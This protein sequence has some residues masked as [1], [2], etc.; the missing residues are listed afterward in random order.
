MQLKGLR[1]LLLRK[2]AGDDGFT[3]LLSMANDDLL[4]ARVIESLAKMSDV[5]DKTNHALFSAAGHITADREGNSLDAALVRDALGHHLSRYKAALQAAQVKRRPG[6]ET[7]ASSVDHRKIADKHLN[8]FHRIMHL[9]VHKL[10]PN[11]GINAGLNASPEAGVHGVN[12]LNITSGDSR[13]VTS[14][15]PWER[16]YLG[17]LKKKGGG[18]QT[19]TSGWE[20]LPNSG[21]MYPNHRY[22]EMAPHKEFAKSHHGEAYPFH[23]I[24]VNGKYVNIEDLP[25]STEYEP[26]VFDSHPAFEHSHS[27][28]THFANMKPVPAGDR[29][30]SVVDNLNDAKVDDFVNK[31]EDWHNSP[32]L[33]NWLTKLEDK[34]KADPSLALTDGLYPSDPIMKEPTVDPK[35]HPIFGNHERSSKHMENAKEFNNWKPEAEEETPPPPPQATEPVKADDYDAALKYMQDLG[36][37]LPD[38]MKSTPEKK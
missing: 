19:V 30:I 35:L 26:H 37:E 25:P 28:Q 10:A 11:S 33:E 15:H 23:E 17:S 31:H 7:D 12:N 21:K 16:N 1:D 2:V 6:S 5:G 22:L 38:S 8:Q 14:P 18:R 13:E 3:A 27:D 29:N 36:V 24:K 9:A 34:H 32:E 20:A 4:I